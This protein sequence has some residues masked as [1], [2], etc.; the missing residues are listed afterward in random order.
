MIQVKIDRR[1]DGTIR[2]FT[3]K[4]H[5]FYSDPGKDIVCAGVSAVAVGTVNSIE[6]LAGVELVS[7]MKD[8]YLQAS[9]PDL[10]DGDTPGRVQLL[11]ESMIV[12]LRAIEESYGDFV[13]VRDARS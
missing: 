6:A 7:R 2:S 3:V 12:M 5:A 13:V 8:G 1:K 9:V 10:P 4:G 11:L